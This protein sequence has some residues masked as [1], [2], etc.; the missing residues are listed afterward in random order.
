MTP[1]FHRTCNAHSWGRS[2]YCFSQIS[3]RSSRNS[4][5]LNVHNDAFLPSHLQCSQSRAVSFSSF[6]NVYVIHQ[7]IAAVYLNE[8]AC[9]ISPP[10]AILHHTLGNVPPISQLPLLLNWLIPS[11]KSWLSFLD[12]LKLVRYLFHHILYFCLLPA[13]FFDSHVGFSG[14]LILH[15]FIFSIILKNF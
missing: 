9:C 10:I 3:M 6:L 13:H 1:F 7:E 4:R 14:W 8:V 2:R 11:N 5:R 15:V 12:P